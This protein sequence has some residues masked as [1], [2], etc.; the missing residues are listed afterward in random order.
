MRLKFY[1]AAHLRWLSKQNAGWSDFLHCDGDGRGGATSINAS[2]Q[3]TV[4]SGNVAFLYRTNALLLTISI[5]TRK[6]KK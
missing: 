5:E 1:P 3:V 4:N 6:V 2:E